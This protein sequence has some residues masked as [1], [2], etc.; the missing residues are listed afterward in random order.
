MVQ[1]RRLVTLSSKAQRVLFLR[2]ANPA[3]AGLE[4]TGKNRGTDYEHS[5]ALHSDNLD[6]IIPW[7]KGG[8][9]NIADN[10]QLLCGRH[11]LEK[12]DKIE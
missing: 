8:S 3:A 10:I 9:S 5:L 4:Q 2:R 1:S 6:H 7:S 12:H 11:N